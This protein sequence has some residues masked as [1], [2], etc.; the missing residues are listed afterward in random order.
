MSD[1][2]N[3]IKTHFQQSGLTDK[4]RKALLRAIVKD[5]WPSLPVWSTLDSAVIEEVQKVTVGC[6]VVLTFM[7]NGVRNVL[8]AQAGDHYQ[9]PGTVLKKSYMIPGGFINLTSTPGSTLVAPAAAPEDA[10]TGTARE[11]E[12]EFRKADGTPLLAIDP[13][14]LKPM[15]TK[16]LSFGNG[17]K[18]VVIGLM[19]ELTPQEVKT[20][21]DHTDRLASDT[22]YRN[23]TAQQTINPDT[24]R[25]E[26]A[27][28]AIFSLADVAQGKVELLHKDQQSL[29]AIVHDHFQTY[30]AAKPAAPGPQPG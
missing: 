3:L 22:L 18:R 5:N 23:A 16:T 17:E 7:E 13:T 19:L 9:K 8:L 4:E 21:R 29:F 24:G 27:D 25:P 26:V 6:G 2:A 11:V 10:R 1:I 12:E 28:A 30:A 15:D 14:R 20:V